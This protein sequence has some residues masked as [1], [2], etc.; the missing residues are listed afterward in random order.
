MNNVGRLTIANIIAA[1]LS[2]GWKVALY[3]AGPT[4]GPTDVL[5]DY[6]LLTGWVEADKQALA[7]G[8]ASGDEAAA[9]IVASPVTF[10]DDGSAGTYP[11]TAK[12]ALFVDASTGLLLQAAVDFAATLPVPTAGSSITVNVTYTEGELAP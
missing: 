3:S 4:P 6:T 9:V 2:A 12:G 8:T 5:S 11:Y 1:G 7:F 10:T